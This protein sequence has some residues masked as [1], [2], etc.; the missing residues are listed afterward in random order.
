MKWL[1]TEHKK[2]RTL[3][4][5]KEMPSILCDR[6]N[7]RKGEFITEAISGIE[8]H[9]DDLLTKN[10][11]KSNHYCNM[12][13]GKIRYMGAVEMNGERLVKFPQISTWWVARLWHF[14]FEWAD[15]H[16]KRVLFEFL[17][18]FYSLIWSSGNTY[19][20]LESFHIHDVFKGW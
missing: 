9:K 14:A 8:D 2:F 19:K 16:F 18:K 4:F 11:C 7:Y 15:K 6:D 20:E 17:L 10:K 5:L 3:K 12:E 1:Y 13:N